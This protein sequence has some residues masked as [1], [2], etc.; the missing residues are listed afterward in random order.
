MLLAR[1]HTTL[2]RPATSAG[3][4]ALV[5]LAVGDALGTTLEF[6]T[7][8]L[9]PFARR[10]EGPHRDI[11]GGGPFRVA[12]GQVTDDTMMAVC[13]ARSL[14]AR[15]ELDLDDLAARYVAWRRV[16]FD[17]G[18]QTA[19]ALDRLAAGLAPLEAGLATWRA[20]G[21]RAAG[22]GSLMRT[23]PVGVLHA[24]EHGTRVRV[25]LEDSLVTHADPACVLACAAHDG[26]I[27]AAV[28]GEAA[29]PA[30]MLAAARV[31]AERAAARYADVVGEPEA[32]ARARGDL[33]RDL[34]LAASA[35][36]EL[37]GEV[38]L[39]RAQGWVRVA[40]RLSFWQLLHAPSF[41]EGLVDCVNRGGDADT[42][43]AITGALLGALHGVE[44]IPS[45]WRDAVL[46]AL[47]GETGPFATEY[48]PR[49]FFEPTR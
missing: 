42:N 12:K 33:A 49:A 41:D 29:T 13:L 18:A 28:R 11:V 44:R 47:A 15:P 7:P 1:G 5:G 38:H 34:E 9:T 4:G 14:A 43:G 46:G 23:T 6:S 35:D 39:H 31:D 21:G 27:A 19:A 16:S 37:E 2:G 45:A 26:A 22:N 32:L 10:L 48:H 30:D 40:T 25:A 20:S 8:S 3:D 24:R 36:P 17:V